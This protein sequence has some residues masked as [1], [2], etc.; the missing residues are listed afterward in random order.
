MEAITKNKFTPINSLEGPIYKLLKI[1]VKDFAEIYANKKSAYVTPVDIEH[2]DSTGSRKSVIYYFFVFIPNN[3]ST[4][5]ELFS[6][7][8]ENNDSSRGIFRTGFVY[9]EDYRNL[10]PIESFNDKNEL[11]KIIDK[12]ITKNRMWREVFAT[13][14]SPE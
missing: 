9:I 1:Y 6:V 12:H 7:E 3:Q 11:E 10:P 2:E 13:L 8:V 4:V 14:V 5:K